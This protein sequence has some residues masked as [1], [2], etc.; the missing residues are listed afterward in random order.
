MNPAYTSRR[1][2]LSRLGLGALSIGAVAAVAACGKSEGGGAVKCDD[3][4]GLDDA[5]KATRTA[6]KY[7]DTSP[8]PAKTCVKCQQ[9]IV[10]EGGAACGGCKLFK[11]TVAPN[12]NCT[13]FAAKA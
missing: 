9:Y 8:D 12:G 6:L 1:H 5:S 7:A 13:G 4:T 10:P 2:F 3:T 11:G